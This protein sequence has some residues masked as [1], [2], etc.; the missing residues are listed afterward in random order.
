MHIRME[1]QK[2]AFDWNRAR[3]FLVTAEEG[4]FSAAA[5][6][7]GQA[8]PTLGRRVAA[9]EEDLGVALFERVGHRL[10][11][12]A[13]GLELLEQVRLMNAAAPRFARIAAGQ[14]QSLD[15]V[16]RIGASQVVA[17]H[18]LPAVIE[19]LRDLHPGIEIELVVSDAASDLRLREAD[20]AVRHFRPEGDDLVARC[21]KQKSAAY[22]YGSTAYLARLGSPADAEALAAAASVLAFDDTPRF[23]DLVRA[24]GYP[25]HDGAFAVRTPDQLVQWSLAKQGLG[26]CV[27]MEEVGDADDEMQRALPEGAPL[28]E[29]PIWLVSHREV[30]TSLR[31]RVVL[32]ALASFFAS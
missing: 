31:V 21:V 11:L 12:T 23:R 14:S 27:M 24:A 30:R 32:D 10:V 19:D 18:L 29:V 20:I 7:V 8:Q 2:L 5:R 13:T 6:A 26:L 15:G 16:V 22:L 9:L 25:F 3:A 17:A 28:I 1:W 4:S